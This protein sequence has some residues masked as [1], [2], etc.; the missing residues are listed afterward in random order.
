LIVQDHI[1]RGLRHVANLGLRRVAL[2]YRF[3]NPHII[4]EVTKQEP[5]QFGSQTSAIELRELIKSSVRFEHL[6]EGASEKYK[7]RRKEIAHEA[8]GELVEIKKK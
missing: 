3:L 6:V 1:N 4:V 7:E 5:P 2:V 8:Y